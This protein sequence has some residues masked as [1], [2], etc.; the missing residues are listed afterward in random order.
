[1][2]GTVPQACAAGWFCE[3][4]FCRGPCRRAVPQG[5]YAWDRAASPR[6]ASR[7][8]SARPQCIDAAYKLF[9]VAGVL[10]HDF[11]FPGFKRAG[12]AGFHRGVLLRWASPHKTCFPIV[13]DGHFNTGQK[14]EIVPAIRAV[15]SF[16]FFPGLSLLC[17]RMKT[18][19]FRAVQ[20]FISHFSW[21]SARAEG[22]D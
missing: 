12:R 4:Q 17:G 21:R 20:F 2:W 22:R 16:F 3:R 19:I 9:F 11:P 5:G 8:N 1:M 13:S 18:A 14:V 7:G 6:R 10:S 15:C